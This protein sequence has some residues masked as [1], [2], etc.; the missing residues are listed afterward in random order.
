MATT[1]ITDKTIEELVAEIATLHSEKGRLEHQIE[2]LQKI[3]FD[4]R[5]EKKVLK[6]ED[7]N[8]AQM[9]LFDETET[10]TIPEHT[11][12]KKRRRK[13]VGAALSS[14]EKKR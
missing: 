11:R 7:E 13:I 3:I 1:K 12:K 8:N 4:S 2:I 9:S 14:D 5:S 6:T 10:V